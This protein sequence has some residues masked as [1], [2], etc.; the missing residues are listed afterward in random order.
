MQQAVSEARLRL[1]PGT[2]ES[3]SGWGQMAAMTAARVHSSQNEDWLMRSVD[4]MQK[5]VGLVMTHQMHTE[6]MVMNDFCF[7]ADAE[8][9]AHNVEK[10]IVDEDEQLQAL[11]DPKR[12]RAL[13]CAP[14][15]WSV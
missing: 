4:Q 11:L 2:A 1:E 8:E 15:N 5:A 12:D 7:F 13:W 9:E 10:M 3:N 6:R 14:A